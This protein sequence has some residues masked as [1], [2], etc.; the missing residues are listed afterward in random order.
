M[1][2]T[3]SDIARMSQRLAAFPTKVS[4]ELVLAAAD[5]C[6]MVDADLRVQ[7]VFFGNAL[8]DVS[9][10]RWDGAFLRSVVAPEG[11]RKIDL[12]WQEGADAISG[13]RHLNFRT[14]RGD[15]TLPLLIKRIDVGGGASILL[16][17]DLRPAVRMQ[18]QF[19][20]AMME[21]EQSYRD[22]F[23]DPFAPP[24]APSLTDVSGNDHGNCNASNLPAAEAQLQ[25]LVNQTM[26]E[27]G[28]Q[29]VAQIV[30]QTA[31]V[32]EDMC[33]REAYA[34]SQYDLQ[35]TAEVLGMNADDLA[36]RMVALPRKP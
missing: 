24:P 16:G 30:S 13:W 14:H 19:N 27:L 21:M 25:M 34:Q 1:T 20:A 4:S 11:Q 12:L 10:A 23:D 26:G 8:E 6:I 35:K 2:I 28:R 5:L 31:K 9:C 33:I 15:E 32:L 36:Q 17:R 29:P 22:S 7:E 3:T 18:E